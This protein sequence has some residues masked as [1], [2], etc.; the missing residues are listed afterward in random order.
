MVVDRIS[1]LRKF[2]ELL[3]QRLDA[4]LKDLAARSDRASAGP[5]LPMK[6]RL[7]TGNLPK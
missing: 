6:P 3:S 2:S 1:G 4:T 7:H 5:L